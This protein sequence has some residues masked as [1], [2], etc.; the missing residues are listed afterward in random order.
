[1]DKNSEAWR[2]AEERI[3]RGEIKLLWRKINDDLY[4]AP[5]TL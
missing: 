3:G 2:L 4:I 1:M 5:A